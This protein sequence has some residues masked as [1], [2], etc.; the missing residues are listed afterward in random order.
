[1][2]FFLAVSLAKSDKRHTFSWALSCFVPSLA[3]LKHE[4][5]TTNLIFKPAFLGDA[6]CWVGEGFSLGPAWRPFEERAASTKGQNHQDPMT[7]PA[8][9][10]GGPSGV[11]R[12]TTPL[13]WELLQ[14]LI[15]S[16][17]TLVADK[18]G[19]GAEDL[20]KLHKSPPTWFFSATINYW[21]SRQVS[22]FYK[23]KLHALL[24]MGSAQ[25]G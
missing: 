3:M 4:F 21:V 5:S 24:W 22:H 15:C 1:M 9:S 6:G 18:Y 19:T 23:P 16:S 11:I 13:G 17:A 12:P 20:Q 8:M 25:K 14:P 2:S 10:S 7:T